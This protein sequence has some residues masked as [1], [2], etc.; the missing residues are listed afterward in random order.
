MNILLP[1]KLPEGRDFHLGQISV[2]PDPAE[3]VLRILL[4]EDEPSNSYALTKLLEKIGHNVALAENGQQALELLTA[5]DFDVILMDV[6]MP[7]MNG[8][9]ATKTIRQSSVLGMKKDIYIIAMTAYAMTGDRER[10]LEA[11]MNDYIA[12]PVHDPATELWSGR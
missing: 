3:Q 2:Q 1:F 12:K 4:V 11:G 6:Q 9:E 5:Q 10:F 8:M 7:V